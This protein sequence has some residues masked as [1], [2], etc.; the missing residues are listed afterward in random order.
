MRFSPVPAPLRR[1]SVG[2]LKLHKKR[3]PEGA[4]FCGY[5]VGLLDDID[6]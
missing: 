3:A 5:A 6:L 1:L 2:F 4:L